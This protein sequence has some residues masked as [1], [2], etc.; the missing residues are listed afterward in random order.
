MMDKQETSIAVA[1]LY[2]ESD[3]SQQEIAKMLNLSRPTVSRLLQYAKEHG[4][5][6]VRINDPIE[7]MVNLEKQLKK[8]YNLK[9]VS[10]ASAPVEDLAEQKK[11]IGLTAAEYLVKT[12]R[13]G[14]VIGVAW[15]STVYEMAKHLPNKPLKQGAVVQLKG[16]ISLNSNP[17]YAYEI[18]NFC[19]RAFDVQGYYLPLPIMFESKKTKNLVEQDQAIKS[20]LDLGKQ[21]NIA[22]FTVGTASQS[23]L[24]FHLGYK[25]SKADKDILDKNAVGDICSR[26]YDKAGQICNKNIDDRTVGIDLAELI[27]KPVRILVAGGK[28]KIGAIKAALQGNFANILITDNFT[29]RELLR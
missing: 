26:F 14:D 11:A 12:V 5:V 15:G 17:T 6:E 20:I 8:K 25:F 24:I 28:H 3:V 9:S 29:A 21:A 1:K 16:G 4:F 18:L 7:N 13:D 10:I 27:Q 19:S 22:V 2:Y 23:S